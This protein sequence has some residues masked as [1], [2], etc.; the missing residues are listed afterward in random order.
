MVWCRRLL[1]C[2]AWHSCP[3]ADV[4]WRLVI[5]FVSGL[6][7]IL[8]AIATSAVTAAI[9]IKSGSLVRWVPRILLP[10]IRIVIVAITWRWLVS[11]WRMV[12]SIREVIFGWR[13]G[14]GLRHALWLF[15]GTFLWNSWF[16][17]YLNLLLLWLL[18]SDC[19]RCWR[20]LFGFIWFQDGYVRFCCACAICGIYIFLWV[21]W[22]RH[23]LYESV[24]GVFLFEFAV[25]MQGWV[26]WCG[27]SF[28]YLV[29]FFI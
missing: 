25:W 28:F 12:I 22:T 2:W 3:C 1:H 4:L 9:E 26:W 20:L 6:L 10:A 14:F 5:Y 7:L 19:C 17:Q 18:F 24:A 21:G 13:H 27:G 8:I 11:I 29:F 23:E 15:S 16:F